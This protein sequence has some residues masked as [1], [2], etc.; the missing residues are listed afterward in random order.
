MIRFALACAHDHEFEGWFRSN[1]AFDEQTA[2]GTLECPVCGDRTV[3]KA[4]MAPAVARSSARDP[5]AGG[6]S[7]AALPVAVEPDPRRAAAARMLQLMRALQRH[8]QENFENVGERFPEEVRKIHYGEVDP[9]DIY[10]RATGE[11]VKELLE[12]GVPI[13]PLPILPELDG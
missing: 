2:G 8:V 6:D 5:H 12:E 7:D 9:R 3:R 13:R 1:E 10:G 11:E 4:I